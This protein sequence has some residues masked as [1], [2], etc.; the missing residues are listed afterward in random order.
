MTKL[1]SMKH[2]VKSSLPRSLTSR[3]SARSTFSNTP[4]RTHSWKRRWHV[5]Y[6]G[7]RSG[8]SR[9]EAPVRIIHKIPFR[10]SRSSTLGLPRPSAR[11][12]GLGS[13]AFTI[14]HCSSLRSI[15][16]LPSQVSAYS[17]HF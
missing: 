7:Y 3:T 15:G 2:S 11:T 17:N 9:Q 10:I 5:W 8:R 16:S 1:P 12:L 13:S 14:A 4:A 6:G